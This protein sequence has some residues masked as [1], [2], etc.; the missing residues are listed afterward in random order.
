MTEG[1]TVESPAC[2]VGEVLSCYTAAMATW[3]DLRGADWPTALGAGCGLDLREDPAD[4]LL[5]FRHFPRS[6]RTGP[7]PALPLLRVGA[8][9][10]EDMVDGIAAELA[11]SGCVIVVGDTFELPWLH[12]RGHRHEPRWFVVDRRVGDRWHVRDAFTATDEHGVQLPWDGWLGH[13]EFLRAATGVAVLRDVFRL[14][15]RYAFGDDDHTGLDRRHQWFVVVDD[16]LPDEP[17][18][19]PRWSTGAAALRRLAEHAAAQGD[20]PEFYHRYSDDLWTAARHRALFQLRVLRD[21]PESTKDHPLLG[22]L[23][24]LVADWDRLPMLLRYARISLERGRPF[25]PA[26]V[27]AALR[28]LADTEPAIIAAVGERCAA[29]SPPAPIQGGTP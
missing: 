28:G 26:A 19:A 29:D 4:G 21:W 25:S 18:P 5:G 20:R 16:P 15:E 2:V 23:A 11:E 27:V 9:S 7:D 8:D 14:R 6:P 12:T 22:E 17:G 3:L 1:A 10:P 13:D 24:E